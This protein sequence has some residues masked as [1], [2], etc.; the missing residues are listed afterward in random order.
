M[1]A[2]INDFIADLDRRRLLSRIR[3]RVDPDLE[4]AAVTDR[5][6]KLPGGGPGLLFEQANRVRHPG[7]HQSLWL[8]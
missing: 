1:Y 5:T 8:D 3:E 6:C 7:R 2:D 4:I